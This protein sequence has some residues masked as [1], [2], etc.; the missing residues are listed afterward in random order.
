MH[1]VACTHLT[2]LEVKL[3]KWTGSL[4]LLYWCEVKQTVPLRA[5]MK[6]R[7]GARKIV[8]DPSILKKCYFWFPDHFSTEEW[9]SLL[10]PYGVNTVLHPKPPKL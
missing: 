3:Q 9:S 10:Y 6:V 2:V 4:F 8:F 7:L 5:R 1:T